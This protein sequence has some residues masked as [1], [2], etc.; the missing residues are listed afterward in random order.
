MK[1]QNN[2]E[3]N[4]KRKCWLQVIYYR[5]GTPEKTLWKPHM[6]CMAKM[7]EIVTMA[8]VHLHTTIINKNL[9]LVFNST[10]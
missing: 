2:L 7:G 10:N 4:R 3:K 9:V 5:N 6:R 1:T 8:H